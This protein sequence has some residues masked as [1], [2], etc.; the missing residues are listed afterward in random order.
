M[1]NVLFFLLS[2]KQKIIAIIEKLIE[3]N[4]KKLAKIF[5]NISAHDACFVKIL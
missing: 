4:D 5:I 3:I 2:L 1:N